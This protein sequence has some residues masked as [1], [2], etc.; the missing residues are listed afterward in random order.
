MIRASKRVRAIR[1]CAS[2]APPCALGV[3]QIDGFRAA[4]IGLNVKGHALAFRED[5]HARGLDRCRMHENVFAA[6]VRSDEAE[7]FLGIEELYCSDHRLIVPDEVDSFRGSG[8][9]SG[10]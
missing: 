8:C 3:L 10:A 4:R 9:S 5:A 2:R 1:V 6:A 7:A